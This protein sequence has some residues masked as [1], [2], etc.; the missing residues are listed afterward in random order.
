MVKMDIL[1]MVAMTTMK[2]Y[3]VSM[4]TLRLLHLT[5]QTAV[6]MEMSWYNLNSDM[7]K[8]S[9]TTR[10]INYP[11]KVEYHANENPLKNIF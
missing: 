9:I 3:Q 1:E 2:V 10:H 4:A 8:T 6:T 11:F 5:S 7:L